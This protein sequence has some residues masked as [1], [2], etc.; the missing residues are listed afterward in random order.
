MA[1]IMLRGLGGLRQVMVLLAMLMMVWKM[2]TRMVPKRRVKPT[3]PI[4]TPTMMVSKIYVKISS[5]TVGMLMMW[6]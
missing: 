1:L 2:P 6:K 3:R 4:Q 5:E